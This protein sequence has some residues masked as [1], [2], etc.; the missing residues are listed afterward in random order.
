MTNAADKY[1]KSELPMFVFSFFKLFQAFFFPLK[2]PPCWD[3]LI[4]LFKKKVLHDGVETYS[5]ECMEE[6]F[7]FLFFHKKNLSW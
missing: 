4:Q 2:R 3:Y 1:V 6:S 7:C 5:T